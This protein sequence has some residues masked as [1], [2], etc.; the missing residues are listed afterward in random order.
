MKPSEIFF[1][2]PLTW[3][4]MWMIPIIDMPQC[5]IDSFILLFIFGCLFVYYSMYSIWVTHPT[6]NQQPTQYTKLEY[7]KYNTGIR[8]HKPCHRINARNK[9]NVTNILFFLSLFVCVCVCAILTNKTFNSPYLYN[10]VLCE[11]WIENC[12]DVNA[13]GQ[14][15]CV[16][17]KMLELCPSDLNNLNKLQ[18]STFTINDSNIHRIT[19]N[20]ICIHAFLSFQSYSMWEKKKK[21]PFDVLLLHVHASICVLWLGNFRSKKKKKSRFFLLHDIH[22]SRYVCWKR[23]KLW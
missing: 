20:I 14:C 12:F 22:W 10:T 7:S 9:I 15:A 4:A 1:F 8:N 17:F 13:I 23:F 21:I 11:M 3:Q 18:L 6:D 2:I 19:Q 5:S 16:Y